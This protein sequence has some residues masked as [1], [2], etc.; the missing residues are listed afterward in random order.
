MYGNTKRIANCI[1]ESL[2]KKGPVT[3]MNISEASP[4]NLEGFDLL[5]VGSP[6]QG[7]LATEAMRNFLKSIPASALKGK[8]TAVFDTRFLENKQRFLLRLLMRVIGYAAP[9][10]ANTLEGKGAILVTPPIGFIVEGKSGPLRSGEEKRAQ[11][12]ISSFNI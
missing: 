4:E 10:M 1:G 12:W 11:N 2:K 6:V 9:R 8:K 7:G 3:F 5:V